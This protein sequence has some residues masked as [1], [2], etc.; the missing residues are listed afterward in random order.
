MILNRYGSINFHRT[1]KQRI[2][3][4]TNVPY[5]FRGPYKSFAVFHYINNRQMS[6]T[7]YFHYILIPNNLFS[8]QYESNTDFC[9]ENEITVVFCKIDLTIGIIL[10]IQSDDR[11]VTSVPGCKLHNSTKHTHEAHGTCTR[12]TQNLLNW[13]CYMFQEVYKLYTFC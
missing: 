1:N 10:I 12:S 8:F 5:H 9:I 11:S 13:E 7:Y 6:E 4:E 3:H 2:V